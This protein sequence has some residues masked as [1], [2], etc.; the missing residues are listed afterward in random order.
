MANGL[1]LNVDNVSKIPSLEKA[2]KS[3]RINIILVFAEWCGACHKFRKNIWN[4]MMRKGALHNR[5]AVRDDMVGKSSLANTKFDYLPSILV[6]DEKGVAQTF[7]TPEGKVTNAT[8][9]PKNLN[10]MVRMVNVPVA[11]AEM[12]SVPNTATASDPTAAPNTITAP[13]K[14]NKRN[15][16]LVATNTLANELAN[17]LANE[18]ANVA[19]RKN[20]GRKNQENAPLNESSLVVSVPPK[21]QASTIPEGVVYTPTPLVAPQRG[22][23]LLAT[24]ESASRGVVP[25]AVLGGLALALKGGGGKRKTSRRKAPRRK[26]DRRTRKHK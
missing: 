6:V 17:Q 21:R 18:P 22:G 12:S 2:L 10:D 24:L 14:N 13:I 8:P 23:N 3:G 15:N 19:V 5:I 9:T 7:K 16:T 1:T 4:P 20:A 26:V 11:P 25:A